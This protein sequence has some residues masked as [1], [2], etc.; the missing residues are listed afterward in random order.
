MLDIMYKKLK[1]LKEY[2]FLVLLSIPS[3]L[4][5]GSNSTSEALSNNTD[6]AD[7]VLVITLIGGVLTIL[8]VADK[9]IFSKKTVDINM[10]KNSIMKDYEELGVKIKEIEKYDTASK[11]Q[12]L[13]T[14]MDKIDKTV[15]EYVINKIQSLSENVNKIETRLNYIE[16]SNTEQKEELSKLSSY[17]REDINEVKAIIMNLLMALNPK[18]N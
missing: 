4:L 17:L 13:H 1:K 3:L 14:T 18:K 11:I 16:S 15:N 7:L 8:T 10:I 2:I 12:S 9:H 5:A 6:I